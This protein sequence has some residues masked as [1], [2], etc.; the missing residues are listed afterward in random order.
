MRLL[1]FGFRQHLAGGIQIGSGGLAAPNHGA[2]AF[3][4]VAAGS[5]SA[6]PELQTT[7]ADERLT[8]TGPRVSLFIAAVKAEFQ[9]AP[10]PELIVWGVPIAFLR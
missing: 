2:M 1:G 9:T 4:T 3:C 8:I 10:P 5:A 7:L 6:R